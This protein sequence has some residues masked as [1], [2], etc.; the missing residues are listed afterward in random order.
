MQ[1]NHRENAQRPGLACTPSAGN[2]GESQPDLLR[3]ALKVDPPLFLLISA[4][5]TRR[6]RLKF[7]NRYSALSLGS[8]AHYWRV[9]LALVGARFMRKREILGARLLQHFSFSPPVEEGGQC[10]YDE[11][12]HDKRN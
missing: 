7:E 11:H 3:H 6:R 9:A 12:Q 4:H 5:V 2:S 8:F 1:V 10:A